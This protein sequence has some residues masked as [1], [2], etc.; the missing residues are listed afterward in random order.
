MRA[1]DSLV[2]DCCLAVWQ[3][4]L[5]A[6]IRCLAWR[7]RSNRPM[8]AHFFCSALITVP[9]IIRQMNNSKKFSRPS[10]I[11][12]QSILWNPKFPTIFENSPPYIQSGGWDYTWSSIHKRHYTRPT[13]FVDYNI[14]LLLICVSFGSTLGILVKCILLFDQDNILFLMFLPLT[15]FRTSKPRTLNPKSHSRSETRRQ[16]NYLRWDR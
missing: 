4:T 3:Q 9:A 12:N 14:V 10:W 7:A 2:V 6:N 5:L 15:V 8:W 11:L 16:C 13:P 1:M